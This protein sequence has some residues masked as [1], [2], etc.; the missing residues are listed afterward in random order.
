MRLFSA[1]QLLLLADLTLQPCLVDALSFGEIA[2]VF[3]SSHARQRRHTLQQLFPTLPQDVVQH[4]FSGFTYRRADLLIAWSIPTRGIRGYHHLVDLK[5]GC[6]ENLLASALTDAN[7]KA[8][9]ALY[10][11]TKRSQLTLVSEIKRSDLGGADFPCFARVSYPHLVEHNFAHGPCIVPVS[12]SV[13]NR[14]TYTPMDYVLTLNASSGRRRRMPGVFVGKVQH[15]GRLAPLGAT[16]IATRLCA[17]H[18]GAF[19][20]GQ[21]KLDVVSSASSASW[22]QDGPEHPVRVRDAS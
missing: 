6:S 12:V 15:R 17:T 2:A 13:C 16:T 4:V 21:W 10:D 22:T 8:A 5:L 9:R 19:D 3:H 11:E 7:A 14:S 18:E 20:A 1:P